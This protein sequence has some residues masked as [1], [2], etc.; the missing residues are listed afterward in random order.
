VR[1]AALV[2]L[3][4]LVST[5]WSQQRSTTV[6]LLVMAHGG[7]D[8]WNAAVEQAILPL[9]GDI[10]ISVAF[11]MANP[12][13]MQTALDELVSKGITSVAVVR[14]FISGKSFLN[15]TKFAF[16]LKHDPPDGYFTYEPKMLTISIPVAIN[17]DGLLDAAEMG[18]IL[19]DRAVQLSINPRLESILVVGHGPGDDHENDRW[20]SVM[21]GYADTIRD[22]ANFYQVIV[23][24]LRE[25]WA[26]KREVVEKEL[27]GFVEFEKAHGRT[28]IIVPFRLFGFGP[29]AE[30]FEGL[31]YR[32]DG[33]GLLPDSRIRDWIKSQYLDVRRELESATIN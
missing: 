13:T 19:A 22:A 31:S 8:T 5:A 14:L 16:R 28:V 29:Y 6:G 21:E 9:R 27:H 17:N 24:T 10:P 1:Y 2:G 33:L 23:S 7:T 30:V 12:H 18:S 32:A 15:E 11:G 26:G 3:C 25:D 20:L 4:L